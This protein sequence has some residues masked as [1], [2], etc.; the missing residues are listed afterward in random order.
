MKIGPATGLRGPFELDY[1]ESTPLAFARL[2][3]GRHGLPRE[4]IDHNH[5]NRLM[6]AAIDSFGE[7]GYLGSSVATIVEAAGVSRRT[8]YLCFD[9]KE[10]CFLNAYDAVIEWLEGK[11]RLAV[12]G[13]D[14]WSARV[15]A[16]TGAVFKLLAA[17]VRLA[18][19]CAY[20]ILLAGPAAESR[21]WAL[22]D[23]LSALLRVGREEGT[24]GAD[25]PPSLERM[26]IGGAV[27][28]IAR[29]S[30]PGEG[31]R[32]AGLVPEATEFLLAP[33]L[34]VAA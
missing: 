33:Y 34:R 3:V 14:G 19:L 29:F 5:R 17:D 15:E 31:D 8:F 27:S 1:S 21:H 11:A 16:A 30:G 23:R 13:A 9:N 10:S 24:A 26:L 32:L 7:R 28:L 2:P 12:E 18:R 20:E 22:V 25:L 4:F 6:A